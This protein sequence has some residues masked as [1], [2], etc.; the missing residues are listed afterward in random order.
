MLGLEGE[1]ESVILLDEHL[2]EIPKG[3]AK[4][5]G[6]DT[7]DKGNPEGQTLRHIEQGLAPVS[8]RGK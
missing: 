1:R 8:T 3:N 4:S 7:K 2:A 6:T 5:M